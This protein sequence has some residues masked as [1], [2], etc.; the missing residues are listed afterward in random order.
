MLDE[1]NELVKCFRMT[2]DHF[3]EE[4]IIDLRNV[5]K[6]SR[7]TTGRKNRMTPSNEVAA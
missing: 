1:T 7:S 4:D 2:R 5:I 6:A 3:K